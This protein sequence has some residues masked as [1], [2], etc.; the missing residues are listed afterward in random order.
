MKN[1]GRI[2]LID[3]EELIISMLAR[4]LK[5]EGYE[6]KIQTNADDV[7]DK[8]ASW[9]PDL[10]LLDIH[11]EENR[12]GL[13]ILADIKKEKLDTE[14]VMLTADDTAESAIRAMKLGAADYLTKPFNIDE[15]KI[16]ISTILEKTKLKEELNYLRKTGP[17]SLGQ[18]VVGSSPVMQ[19][20]LEKSRKI[21][22]AKAQTVLITGES[23]TG[24]EVLAR[25]IHNWRHLRQNDET[26]SRREI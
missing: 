24:K 10:I 14:V 2:F 22:E 23:G 8:I 18:S 17:A 7:I 20:I 13:D 9:H 19:Q 5:K 4:S 3:D 6:T 21:A 1:H 25:Y 15:V 26:V 12:T 11:L 16:V